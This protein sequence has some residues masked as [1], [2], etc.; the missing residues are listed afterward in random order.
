VVL[1]WVAGATNADRA[2]ANNQ[3][4][5]KDQIKVRSEDVS[6]APIEEDFDLETFKHFFDDDAWASVA[7]LGNHLIPMLHVGWVN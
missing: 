6:T 4:L 1:T 7:S 3:K 2:L 5:G